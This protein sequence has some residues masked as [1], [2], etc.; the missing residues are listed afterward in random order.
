MYPIYPS[1]GKSAIPSAFSYGYGVQPTQ[2]QYYSATNY[3]V[4]GFVQQQQQQAAQGGASLPMEQSFIENILRL[5]RGKQVTV[6]MTFENNS[7]WNA[8]IFKGRLEEAGRDHIIISDPE[9]G[10]YYLLLMVNL[11]YVVFDEPI[12]YTYPYGGGG[13]SLTQYSP[14]PE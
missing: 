9:S 8:K 4:P 2:G 10:K 5:N 7:E 3:Q 14:R 6:Y 1:Y 12:D 11:D 13:Q